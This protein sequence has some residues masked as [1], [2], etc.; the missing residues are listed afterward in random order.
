MFAH[1][2]YTAKAIEYLLGITFLL[3]FI[4]FW[5]YATGGTTAGARV[6][7]RVKLRLPDMFRLPEGVLLHPGHAWA[8]LESPGLAAIGMDDFAQQLVGQ[9][10][11]VHLPQVGST[12]E[13]GDRAWTLKTNGKSV[14]MLSPV[15]GR[16]VA[17]NDAVLA[18]PNAIGTDP[19]GRGWLVKVQTP[20]FAA[21]SKQLLTG[22]SARHH[23]SSSW[24]ELSGM[25]TPA[26]GQTMHDGG[27]PVNGFARGIDQENWDAVARHF[28]LS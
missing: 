10:K 3:L 15:S 24:D 13:Q 27:T 11:A 17:V 7:E 21:N 26:L 18:S 20:R 25:L 23:L 14:D 6:A 19:Y 5:Q 4:G 16:V 2:P 22:N 9:L 8:R 12:V 28:L 1:D